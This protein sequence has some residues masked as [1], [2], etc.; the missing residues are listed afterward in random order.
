MCRVI[1]PLTPGERSNPLFQLYPNL[2]DP[3]PTTS[4]N[5]NVLIEVSRYEFKGVLKCKSMTNSGIYP[6]ISIVICYPELI[7]CIYSLQALNLYR[8]SENLWRKKK[9][10]EGV[11]RGATRKP[12]GC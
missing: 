4:G 9:E 3:S 5:V 1:K 12:K 11:E 6:N 10:E 2:L 8:L 7:T